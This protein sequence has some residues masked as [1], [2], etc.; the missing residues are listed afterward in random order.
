MLLYR[1]VSL[2]VIVTG[3]GARLAGFEEA[4]KA[5][6]A[7]LPVTRLVRAD[8]AV[9]EG[10][11][12]MGAFYAGVG[13]GAERKDLDALTVMDVNAP[14]LGI[15]NEGGVL[16]VPFPKQPIP[17]RSCR[18]SLSASCCLVDAPRTVRDASVH[19]Q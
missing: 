5:Q 10:L 15:E 19:G 3:G 1:S 6:M 16:C 7:G 18:C 8:E 13:S 12:I 4:V 9:A 14:R 2:Q 17:P 11:G